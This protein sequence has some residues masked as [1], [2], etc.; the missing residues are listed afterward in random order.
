MNLL[1]TSQRTVYSESQALIYICITAILT[2]FA[3]VSSTMEHVMLLLVIHNGERCLP[4]FLQSFQLVFSLNFR[5]PFL[6][7]VIPE[8]QQHR[9]QE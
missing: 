4:G 1:Y 3:G 6:K 5:F 9:I 2:V 8:M 7:I